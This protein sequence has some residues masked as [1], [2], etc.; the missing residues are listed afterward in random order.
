[1]SI[2]FRSWLS[3][4][5]VALPF[6]ASA[7]PVTFNLSS[8]VTTLV[9]WS[10][11]PSGTALGDSL[12]LS[13]SYDSGAIPLVATPSGG[14]TRYDFDPASLS[15]AYTAGATT[16]TRSVTPLAS[17]SIIMRDNATDPAFFDSVDGLTFLINDGVS[18]QWQITLRGPTLDLING[19]SLPTFQDGRWAEQRTAFFELCRFQGPSSTFC[20]NGFL[21]A[22]INAVPE[23]ASLALAAVALAGL[24]LGRRCR[25]QAG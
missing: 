16:F 5:L 13:I 15:I 18:E 23:P 25:P 19:A 7:A 10:G 8:K 24:G 20:D 2:L 21:R 6:A 1:M 9:G 17:A 11:L 14:G 22:N 12:D 4:A 3:A